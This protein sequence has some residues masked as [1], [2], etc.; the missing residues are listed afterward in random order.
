MARIFKF[1]VFLLIVF[2]SNVLLLVESNEGDNSFSSKSIQLSLVSNWGETPSYLEAAEF[3]HNQDK[4]L[5]WK[6]IEEF[7]KID[8]S[9]NYSDKIYYES[10]IS[11]MKSVLSSNTQFLSEFLSIDLAMRTYSPRVETY[12][13]LAI[14]NMK[15]NNIE[16]SIT[17]ADNKT[18][19]LFNSGG[20]VQIKN[21][22]ITDV[23][24]INESLF[25]DVAVVDDEENEFIRLYDFDHI[26]PTL[27]NTVSSS[28]SSPSSIPIVILY[29]DIKSEFFKL[30]HPKL[31]Q[32][33]QM[34][35]IKYCLRYVVQESNQKLNLQGYGYELSIKNLEYKVMDDSAIKKDIIIDGVKSKTIINIPNEDVQGFNFHKLQKRKPEL[36]SKLSTFRSY[37]MAKSQ[38]AKELKVWELKDLGIQSAQKIIQSGDPLRSLEYISQKFPTLSNSLS[39]ITLNESLKSVIESNQKIIPS[40][41]DQT[42]LLN[43]RLI[44]TNELSPIELSRIILEEYEHSTTIQQQGPLSSKTVQDIISA[45]LPIRI[46]LLPTKEELELN[47]GNEPF[48]SLNNLELDY[49]YRQWE[50]KLQSS[51]LDKPVTS[52]QDIFIRKNLLTTV[53]VLDWNNINTFEIIPEI[54]EMVQG[55]SLIPTRIQLLF[56]TKSNNNN[57]NNNNNNDQN[58]QTSNFIQG[59]DLA[60]VF[61]TI[62]N[63]NLGNRGAFFFITALNYFKKMYIPNELGITRSVLSSSFQAVLQ[64]MGGS[65]RSLQHALTNTDFDNLLESSNQLIERLE[66]LDTTT[67]QSTTTTTTTKILPKVFVN[68]VQVKYSNIDQLSFDLLV[69]LYDEFDNLKPLFKESI[70]STTT[71]QYY[72][73]ILT[74]S[75]WKD[76]NLPFLKKLNS[77]ISNEKYSHLITNSKNRNQEVDAQNV[78][79]NL[80]YFRNNENKDEQ[81]L[82]NLIVIGDFDHYNTRDI[83][84]EL[85]R[86]LEKGELKN[87]KLT[88]ISNPIDINSVVNTAGNENQILGKLITILKHY[89]K[90]LTPQLVIGLFEKVQSDPTIIDSFKTMKQIIEL[91]GFDIA[92]NDI[93]VAQSVN[94]FKQSSKVCKQYL[95]IQSTN[96]SP[97]SILV[98]GRI[99][100]PPLSY[101]DAASFIQSDFKL[102]LE[103]EMIKA[104]KTFELLN[105]DPILKDKSNLK[106]S[107]LLNKVQSLV[108]YYYN[109]NNQLDSN[110]KRKRIPNSLSISFSHKPPTLSSSSSSSSSNSN[111]VPLKFLMI[112]NP[113]NK[114]SQK[115][116]PMVREFSNKLNIPVDVILNPPVSLSE[117]PLK[118][119]YTYV[120]KLSSEFNNE[121]VLYNQPLGIATD[122]PEDRV[123]TLALDI[124]SSWLVQPIIAKYDLDNIRLKDLGDEQVLTAVYELENIVIE[125]SANDMTTDNAPAGLELLLNPIST[126]TNKTQDTIVMNNFGY[127]QLK[128]NPGIWKLTIAPGRSSDIMDMVDH[129]NQKEKETFVI[130]PHRLVVIDSLYQ[131]LSSL[132]VVRKAGQELRPILQP[133]DEYEKQ[134]E[135]E[136]E[137]K[138]KQNSSGFFSNLFSSKNDATDSV[139]THQKKSNLDTIHIFSVASGHLY[140]RFLKIMMLSVVKNTESPIKFWFLKNYL[141]PAF[142]EF[143]PE[144]AKEY[145]F[146]YELVTYKWPWW[147]RKQTEKQRIIWSYK[148]LFLDVLFPLDVPKIIF[149]DADQVVR[150]DLKELWDMDLHGASLGYTPFCDS[151]KDTEGFR[152]WKSGYWRQHL[153]GRSYHIS[154]LYVVDLVRFRRLAAGD[155]LRA[156]YDQLSRDPNSLAN[157]DQDLPN[158]LQ[159]YVRIHSLPQEWLWCETWCDQESKSKAKTIDLCNNPLTK[160]P[161]LENAVRIIDEWTTL[162]N[163]AKEFE[164]KIDQSKHHRQIELDHQ[165]QLPNSKP[166]ENIDDILLNLAESQKDLF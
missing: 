137:Q 52:P 97:L 136:K 102:L 30:V 107:D 82:L 155:Q 162:D 114:V 59:K 75:Y 62:K 26:F 53:I 103:I 29:V 35:K 116:V 101:D 70:L 86:Q 57:N 42:L 126:Q 78:L 3:L 118:T 41:T 142:K 132:S 128:S 92:A 44:D 34:G 40:T 90:I 131:S 67:S 38:E 9:T 76:N 163:E 49:I 89:G 93:W 43:G 99:I 47:G 18:I 157:L 153:A 96:K 149:V 158:Y 108:G 124:P 72:E 164:L 148:I 151:N 2:I 69:S 100:T 141:S 80:L 83:S 123:V 98:N 117:L 46:Q 95:G 63:S 61:L 22:I 135:Q 21:K 85:L 64:Q 51:V 140:E 160:T 68:G 10:T 15:L 154:A 161:K 28:S 13:Q 109:G 45:Q 138:L 127:Y 133:I 88:F 56:N 94:L 166:I 14:S 8:F 7:N 165:N 87:C 139:A 66:L 11:L 23:N 84:L 12:R 20:W 71:A 31:K 32:F 146:Q 74:S 37:L 65:V 79:K 77:M 145:G 129:P 27:A 110:I 125:G 159:H 134:K 36:T 120:I 1:F 73:T 105:S 119:Y 113:F 19:T 121:N 143:I 16:H 33:S 58:S 91:S 112:I 60:K 111:D 150:T 122:I 147:L 54:Q 50:P 17:T 5:F 115:L 152:F 48:V 106:I 104:K 81:N 6:F 144:M 39:K 130:V 156:T 24:E 25:K 4:S 55:N